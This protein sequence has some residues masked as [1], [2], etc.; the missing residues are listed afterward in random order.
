MDK[1]KSMFTSWKT[2]AVGLFTL[3][4][5]SAE[6]LNALPEQYSKVGFGVCMV[7]VGLGFVAAKD[8]NVSHAPVA[9]DQ[10][11]AS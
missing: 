9:A 4:C 11:K 1:L 7:L 6:L 8:S 10:P 2:T 5:G 3:A